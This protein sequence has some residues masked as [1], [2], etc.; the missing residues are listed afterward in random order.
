MCVYACVRVCGVCVFVCLHLIVCVCHIQMPSMPNYSRRGV[1]AF[2]VVSCKF[3]RDLHNGA[4]P[5]LTYDHPSTGLMVLRKAIN[6]QQ[7]TTTLAFPQR[8]AAP[9]AHAC[10]TVGTDGKVLCLHDTYLG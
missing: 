4:V 9:T 5:P 7:N 6:V 10:A 3:R 2:G 1:A 8:C